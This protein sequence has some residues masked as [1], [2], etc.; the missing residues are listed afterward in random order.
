MEWGDGESKFRL[1]V[2]TV[3]GEE[4]ED[5]KEEEEEEEEEEEAKGE[6]RTDR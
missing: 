5:K 1:L 3:N 6:K 2:S 4:E